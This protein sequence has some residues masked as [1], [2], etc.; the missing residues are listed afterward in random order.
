MRDANKCPQ[1]TEDGKFMWERWAEHDKSF[2]AL[3]T[4]V[5]DV[6]QPSVSDVNTLLR[7][8]NQVLRD[9]LDRQAEIHQRCTVG[10]AES[11]SDRVTDRI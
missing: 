1:R 2:L 10:E 5:A 6:S 8:R 4:R 11:G 7:Q 9:D 3:N